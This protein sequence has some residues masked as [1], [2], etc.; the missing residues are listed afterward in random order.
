[1]MSVF[2]RSKPPAVLL[3]KA[4]HGRPP[5]RSETVADP[6]VPQERGPV[7]MAKAKKPPPPR[8]LTLELHAPGMTPIHR[9]GLGGL[10]A[11]LV[12]LER[13]IKRGRVPDEQIPV[14]TEGGAAWEVTPH[15]VTLTWGDP[16]AAGAYLE[17]LFAF[18][19][20]IADG[21]IDL[22]GTYRA[23]QSRAV[24]AELQHGLTL[25]FLQFGPHRKLAAARAEFLDVN[26]DGAAPLRLD[27]RPCSG[28]LHQNFH[29]KLTTA[30]RVLS[31]KPLSAPSAFNPGAVQRHESVTASKIL[32]PAGEVLCTAFS[33][34][35]CLSLP[36]SYGV[37]VLLAPD[38]TDLTHFARVRPRLTPTA[39]RDCRIAGPA[40]G[41]L[42]AVVRVRAKGL[43]RKLAPAGFAGVHAMRLRP[44]QWNEKQKSRVDALFV[45]NF[46]SGEGGDEALIK[47]DRALRHLP[48]KLHIKAKPETAGR[49]ANA[50]KRVRAEAYFIDSLV[51]PLVADN[52]AR[53]RRWYAGFGDL[54]RDHHSPLTY[55]REGPHAMATD[56]ALTA[57]DELQLIAAVHQA[58]YQEFGKI[59]AEGGGGGI[60]QAVKNRWNRYMERARL[61]LINAKT[62]D[63]TRAAL[64]L[65]LA[66]AGSNQHLRDGEDRRRVHG[67]LFGPDWRR[68]RDLGLFAL[69]SYAPPVKEDADDAADPAQ[70]SGPAP[71][72]EG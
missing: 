23:D 45:P 4:T 43:G 40:D 26:G 19:F 66:K 44:T 29:A 54:A 60:T 7:L 16:A 1:M 12:A 41:A 64:S 21:L 50:K 28:Y 24:R 58:I 59:A 62:E 48:R 53:N 15:A 61:A 39:P 20:Q 51:R 17:A 63:Q 36:V 6:Q 27:P 31:P 22:P 35:G 37:G 55:E 38:V 68:C 71:D 72:T 65:M 13:R 33:A 52:L 9:A 67:L 42:Q 14:N 10:A 46:E 2:S 69:S 30:K 3:A 56:P 57:D 5:K 18:A 32:R 25:S 34:V 49:G 70:D 11:T 8:G 47:F